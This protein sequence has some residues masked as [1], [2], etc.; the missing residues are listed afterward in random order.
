MWLYTKCVRQPS[1]SNSKFQFENAASE[2]LPL[3]AIA[4][5]CAMQVSEGPLLCCLLQTVQDHIERF[6][7]HALA[8]NSTART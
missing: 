5:D 8:P 3:T 1:F 4:I 2:H 7:V 6:A